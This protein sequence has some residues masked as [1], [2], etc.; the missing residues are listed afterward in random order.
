MSRGWVDRAIRPEPKQMEPARNRSFA[1]SHISIGCHV[2]TAF[3]PL[4]FYF[5]YVCLMSFLSCFPTLVLGITST[6]S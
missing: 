1:T 4:P 6:N 2:S 3:Y 5:L